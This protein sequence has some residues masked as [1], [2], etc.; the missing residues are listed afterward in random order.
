M[1]EQSNYSTRLWSDVVAS[2]INSMKEQEEG[3]P[4]YE[5]SNGRKFVQPAKLYRQFDTEPLSE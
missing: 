2:K 4:A 3:E 1:S 5:F